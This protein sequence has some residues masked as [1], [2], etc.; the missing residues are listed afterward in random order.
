MT[1]AYELFDQILNSGA[2]SETLFILIS[3]IKD[4]GDSQ[5][6]IEYCSKALQQYPANIPLRQMLVE[7]L[8]KE[9]LLT[10]AASEAEEVITNLDHLIPIYK[11]LAKIYL[12]QERRGLAFN[13][14]KK[15]LFFQPNDREAQDLL[16][17]LA[18]EKDDEVIEFHAPVKKPLQQPVDELEG[19]P[20][21][22]I[23]AAAPEA[24]SSAPTPPSV[25][26]PMA[27][28][29][30]TEK[31]VIESAEK[32]GLSEFIEKNDVSVESVE[33]H[34]DQENEESR[35]LESMEE[36]RMSETIEEKAQIE[37]PFGL[38]Q[39]S[40]PEE[41]LEEEVVKLELD[42]AEL[43][44]LKPVQ[45]PEPPAPE[46]TAAA[47]QVEPALGP[48]PD[49]DFYYF[50]ASEPEEM[51]NLPEIATPTLAEIYFNQSLVPDAIHTYE[52]VILK[53]PQD[54]RSYNRLQEIKADAP[55]M[56]ASKA[57]AKEQ[58][59]KKKEKLISVLDNWLGKIR[60]IS[61]KPDLA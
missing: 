12:K 19:I 20:M 8:F 55:A 32:M 9:N 15:Y 40:L 28:E 51:D 7:A 22:E 24:V 47:E 6:V 41:A 26:S 2:S 37:Q 60:K 48:Q 17:D 11:L 23:P 56:A 59:K 57:K 54:R 44:E 27:S 29:N 5:S 45:T 21:K 3:E 42:E 25:E 13:I 1:E 35:L 52:K 10:Q 53:N 31:P 49:D 38:E 39:T 30:V 61:E 36:V 43:E 58:S 16:Q 4:Q 50:S 33:L 46:P 18:F 34:S 14:L